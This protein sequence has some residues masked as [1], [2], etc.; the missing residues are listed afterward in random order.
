MGG[1]KEKGKGGV[2]G[3]REGEKEEEEGRKL[4]KG[5]MSNVV[6]D[7]PCNG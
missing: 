2:E 5:G 6:V 7:Y 1:G 3:R 4:R